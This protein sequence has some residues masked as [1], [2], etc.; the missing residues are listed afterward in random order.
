MQK[1]RLKY[2]T[3][4]PIDAQRSEAQA[5]HVRNKREAI[6]GQAHSGQKPIARVRNKG[7]RMKKPLR[8]TMIS[9][10]TLSH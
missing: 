4:W 3:N 1:L 9:D 2:L 6:L 8:F 5:R 10:D 7:V